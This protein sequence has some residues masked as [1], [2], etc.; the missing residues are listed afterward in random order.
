MTSRSISV[1]IPT[2]N[3]AALLRR[4]VDSALAQTVRPTEILIVDDGST[5]DTAAVASTLPAPV[6]YIATPNGGVARARNTG[7]G[8]AQGDW[9]ALLDSDDEWE[10]EKLATQF[11]AL[12]AAP[13]ARWSITGCTLI[14][15]DGRVRPGR[16]SWDATFP[17]FA[18]I[19]DSP[20]EYFGRALQ[21]LGPDTYTGDL[22]ETLFRGNVV[23]PSSALIHRSVF[24]KCGMFDPQFRYAEETQF[25]HRVAAEFP[26]VVLLARLVRYRVA[27]SG[28][29]TS[30]ANTQKLIANALLSLNHAATLRPPTPS[31]RHALRVGSQSL[32][33]RL[34]YAR[35]SERDTRGARSAAAQAWA[36]PRAWGIL[37][38]SLLPASVLGGLHQLKRR[39]R[40]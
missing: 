13:N 26:V 37:A 33:L 29:L 16:Q 21:P 20:A 14:D 22:Y 18:E 32:L 34:A 31:T 25:F 7:I 1:V 28:S 24:E 36:K 19:H 12:D 5:D 2:Y 23:L 17:V 40:A 11:A 3:R 9:I 27:Q 39:F 35:L 10:P 8:A 30:S 15:G 38:A 4:A 6:R